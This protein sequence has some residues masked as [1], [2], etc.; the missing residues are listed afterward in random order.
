MV[1]AHLAARISLPIA[2]I[3]TVTLAGAAPVAAGS[4]E[5][6]KIAATAKNKIGAPYKHYAKGPDKFDCVGFVWW[7]FN[8]HGL[9]ER[10]GGYRGVRGYFKWFKN[11]GLVSK[12][13]PRPG[14]LVVWGRNQHIG[15]YLGGGNAISALVKPY[16]VRVH[17][18]KGWLNVPF[19]A[20]LRVRLER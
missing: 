2:L 15:I 14:D 6:E 17:P 4:T 7:V 13:N 9:K 19:K 1:L 12:S 5:F 8:Q 3:L 20:Y 16:N 18:V 11:R 10:I